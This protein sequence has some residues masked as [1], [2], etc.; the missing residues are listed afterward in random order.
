VLISSGFAKWNGSGRKDGWQLTTDA[1]TILA[2]LED[3]SGQPLA[4]PGRSSS[5]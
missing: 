3:G 1:D 4:L 5:R 2:S